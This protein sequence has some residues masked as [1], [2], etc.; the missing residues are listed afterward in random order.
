M[1]LFDPIEAVEWFDE[2]TESIMIHGGSGQ[3]LWA[4]RTG[5]QPELRIDVDLEVGRAAMRWVP[6]GTHAVELAAAGPIVV[7]ES[8]DRGLVT[9]PAALARVSVATARRAIGEYMATGDRPAGVEWTRSH[10]SEDSDP[11]QT[12]GAIQ[13]EE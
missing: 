10:E 4:G 1:K 11:A 13:I 9:V 7:L 6:D 12:A 2:Q 8:P 5:S 3:T